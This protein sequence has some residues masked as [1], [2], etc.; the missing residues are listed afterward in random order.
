MR[1]FRVTWQRHGVSRRTTL[2]QSR[3]AAERLALVLQGRMGEARPDIDPN[4]CECGGDHEPGQGEGEFCGGRRTVG[5]RWAEQTSRVP[6]LVLLRI[7]SREVGEWERGEP[8][9]L[10]RVEEE[11][12]A[13]VGASD[14]E[15]PEDDIPF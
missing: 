13:A 10:P 5:E 12:M 2:R 14:D 9:E 3:E 15:V 11:P 7:D 6:P 4:W 8:V 1:E